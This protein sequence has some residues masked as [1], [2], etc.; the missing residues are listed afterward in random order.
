[1]KPI[2][3]FQQALAIHPSSAAIHSQFG[4]SLSGEGTG[5][6]SQRRNCK[7]ALAAGNPPSWPPVCNWQRFN[8][9]RGETERRGGRL[10]P[11]APRRREETTILHLALLYLEQGA[12][13]AACAQLQETLTL[14]PCNLVSPV[15]SWRGF[16]GKNVKRIHSVWSA[17]CARRRNFRAHQSNVGRHPSSAGEALRMQGQADEALRSS[18]RFWPS[19]PENA[20]AHKEL[21]LLY[22]RRV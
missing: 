17:G 14:D 20:S 21:E 15:W 8:G 16:I 11:C 4:V 7:K 22:L 18:G 1:M 2:A 3:E 6:R 5:G 13:D 9:Q 12:A 10:L 19:V